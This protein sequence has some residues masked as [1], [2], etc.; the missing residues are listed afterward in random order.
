MSQ[1]SFNIGTVAWPLA[2]SVLVTGFL[3]NYVPRAHEAHALSRQKNQIQ[4]QIIEQQKQCSQQTDYF[5]ALGTDPFVVRRLLR[6]KMKW[7]QP[8]ETLYRF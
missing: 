3:I 5:H 2:I 4:A 6:L 1:R 8:D 7:A